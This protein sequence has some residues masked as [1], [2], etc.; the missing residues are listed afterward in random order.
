MVGNGEKNSKKKLRNF[1]IKFKENG[2]IFLENSIQKLLK[3]LK[4]SMQKLQNFFSIEKRRQ[5]KKFN[6]KWSKIKKEFTGK[7]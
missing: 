6:L 7:K 2:G 5:T 4:N 3:K 1:F